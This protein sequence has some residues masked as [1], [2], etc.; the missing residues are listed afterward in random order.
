MR[1]LKDGYREGIG[2]GKESMIQTGFDQGFAQKGAP[3][4]RRLGHVR[5][6]LYA[7]DTLLARRTKAGSGTNEQIGNQKLHTAV[8]RLK[9]R[10][11]AL[12]MTDVVERDWDA[13]EHELQ[14][15][16]Q[17]GALRRET[18][19]ERAEREGILP[20]IQAEADVLVEKVFELAL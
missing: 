9:Q 17:V 4:G 10:V 5:G 6:T 11:D 8:R 12:Q 15:G 13:M 14:H 20:A 18:D 1:T 3:V 2:N 19:A 16:G 7:L